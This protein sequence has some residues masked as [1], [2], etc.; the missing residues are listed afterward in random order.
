MAIIIV[1]DA[2]SIIVSV[3]G[4][5]GVDDDQLQAWATEDPAD[6]AS[7]DA[8]LADA[9]N[10]VVPAGHAAHFIQQ[11]VDGDDMPKCGCTYVD[12]ST[13][14]PPD[15]PPEVAELDALRTRIADNDG[16][17]TQTNINR[18]LVLTH[19]LQPYVTP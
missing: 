16:T 15:D 11:T 3:K 2:D 5:G 13:F 4:H 18:F 14:T 8:Y 7:I 17:L 10:V 9:D 1:R 6:Q 12:D 19:G